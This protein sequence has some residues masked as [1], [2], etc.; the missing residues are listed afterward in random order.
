M[1]CTWVKRER[2][3]R[4]PSSPVAAVRMCDPAGR[5]TLWRIEF[6]S[7]SMGEIEASICAD[8][9]AVD[10]FSLGAYA[11]LDV[12]TRIA[13]WL[14]DNARAMCV[15]ASLTS[16]LHMQLF[17]SLCAHAHDPQTASAH[18]RTRPR[19]DSCTDTQKARQRYSI[20]ALAAGRRCR[21]HS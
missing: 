20:L 5:R 9:S 10:V 12:R 18:L 1:L 4:R 3:Q 15:H 6:R 21:W 13:K 8:N 17:I 11:P 14:S 16:S 2:A 7:H 19:P